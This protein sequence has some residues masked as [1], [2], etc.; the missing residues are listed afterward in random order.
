MPGVAPLPSYPC[1][2]SAAPST[3]KPWQKQKKSAKNAIT[4]QQFSKKKKAQ[5]ESR[6]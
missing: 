3:G 5:A 4:N 1:V 6:G 2:A